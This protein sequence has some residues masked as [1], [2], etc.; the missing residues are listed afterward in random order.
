MTHASRA[1]SV[2]PSNAVESPEAPVVTLPCGRASMS[3]R[4]NT[5]QLETGK[6][7]TTESSI[8]TNSTTGRN[9]A[10]FHLMHA[11]SSLRWLL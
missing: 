4:V 1:L 7:T 6:Q 2:T 3:A 11:E 9:R 8:R 5:I 10:N